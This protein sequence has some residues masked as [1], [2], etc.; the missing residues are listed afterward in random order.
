MSRPEDDLDRFL[1]IAKPGT[2]GIQQNGSARADQD[3][4]GT[5]SGQC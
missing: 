3:G 4:R 5:F 1:L 2:F